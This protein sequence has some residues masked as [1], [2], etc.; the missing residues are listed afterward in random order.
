MPY[1]ECRTK[2][3]QILNFLIDTGSNKNY[4]QPSLVQNPVPNQEPFF[5][6]SVGGHTKITEHTFITLFDDHTKKL[7]FFLLPTLKSFHG[8]LGNDSLKELS[9]VIYSAGNYMIINGKLKVRIKQKTSHSVNNID[10]RT[11]HLTKEQKDNLQGIILRNRSLFSEPDESLTYTSAVVAEIHTKTD[12]PIYSRYYP[13]PMHLKEEVEKQIQELLQQGII[14]P[15]KSP[16]N[17]PIWIV[18]K[19]ADASGQKKFRIVI[20]Y[21]KLNEQTTPDRYPIPEIND[22]LP[23]LGQNKF[24]SVLDLKSGF[25][26]IPLK[27]T[28]RQKTAF[29]VNNG[30]YEF[31]RL[32]FGLK[33]APSIF[34]RTLDDILREYI[35]KICFVYMDDII[36]FAENEKKHYENLDTI[37]K[38][39]ERAKMKVQLDKCEFLR[40]EV[41]F[42]GF[43]ISNKGI[44][45]NPKKVEAILNFPRPKTLKEL[46]SFLGISNYY[47]RFIRDY[48]KIAKPLTMLLRGEAGRSSKHTSKKIPIDMGQDAIDAF[49]KLRTALASEDVM[50][51]YPNFNKEFCLTTDA[52]N[53]ALGAVLSQDNRPIVFLSR[54]LNRAEEH[55]ATNE[56]EMLAIVWS[57][58][59]LRNYLYGSPKLKI[60]TDHLPLTY[61][62]S[63]KNS[64]FKLKRWKAFLEDYNYELQYKPGSTNVV[65]DALSRPPQ[66]S[67]QIN[68]LTATQHSDESSSHHL[69]QFTDAPLN[70][71]KNQ[72][73]ISNEETQSTYSFEIVFP[74]YHRHTINEPNI[75]GDS[76]I[77][78][79][80]KYL[81]PSVTNCIK[82]SDDILGKLQEIY[83]DNF[84][85]YRA[86]YTRTIVTD[87][88]NEE[89][90]ESE[91][92]KEHNRAHRNS[93]E[94][95]TQLITK[96]YFPQMHSKIKKI[97]KLCK[98]CR[99][100]KY[101]RHPNK[102]TL[103]ET[104][105][106]SYPGQIIHIDIF[107]TEKKI[108]LTAIDK[109][110]K[111]AQTRM[112]RS[113]AI[114]DVKEPL[115]ELILS[116][117]I[118][119]T[120]VMDN[121]K[122]FN[123]TSI[124]FML[125]NEYKIKVFKIP[126]YSSSVNG[127][128]ERFHSTIAELMRCLKAENSHRTF[129]ELLQRAVYEYNNSIHST[130]KK[131]PIETFFLGRV[132]TN[133]QEI[134]RVK[135]DTI[136]RLQQKQVEDMNYHNKKKTI[137]KTYESGETIYV[138]E[139]KRL[140]TKLSKTYRKEIVEENRNTTILTKSG[141]IIHKNNIKN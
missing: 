43:I 85:Q 50:L 136:K 86:K 2:T 49:N 69:I 17:S 121:E 87:L 66:E 117:G 21:R 127:Q 63:C 54:T 128:I 112:L 19:K 105:I 89:E 138:K 56:K 126:P 8:I 26:Q 131:K 114:E 57:L 130:I 32:P 67:S 28:D 78:L 80:K 91:I 37:F 97:T 62:L 93:I 46:R 116:F 34:Q 9:A 29:S 42:L 119:E 58:K 109:F 10:I 123:S 82:T 13:Y 52:S 23:Q 44:K 39:L 72:I 6:N 77:Q 102:I 133:P 31:T 59:S 70:A 11:E 22:V 122:S 90:Q 84:T 27:E 3:G 108:I 139:N 40:E 61:A 41:E 7:K 53:Y 45:T 88:K 18:P 76:L 110:S 51:A 132:S 38:T 30:K 14:R 100:N 35:G 92:I 103:Q 96:F 16:Y 24:F 60:Y 99:E 65:A 106:P 101:D 74:T 20:D 47:R 98:V 1:I 68:A 140:G 111:F 95:K 71:F 118:P 33:N 25:H 5:A 75:T 107:I 36:I 141:K 48:A 55:Y 113:R 134:E 15:S 73:I 124:V 79:L 83:R 64:N 81:N 12:E 137:P 135:L 104:P 120:I 129:A 125:E 115:R 4:I 94:N